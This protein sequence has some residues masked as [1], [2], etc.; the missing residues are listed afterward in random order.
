M[1]STKSKKGLMI[2]VFS[3]LIL[4]A[5]LTYFL[6]LHTIF[7]GLVPSYGGGERFT[8]SEAENYTFQI[9]W[10]AHTK[11]HLTLQ[12]NDIV[13]LYV[14]NEYV[15]DCTHY[16]FVVEPD[17]QILILLKSDAPVSGMFMAWQEVPFENQILALTLVIIGLLGIGVII[18]GKFR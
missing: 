4:F 3:L 18:A 8:L 7:P 15:C 13:E 9:P 1:F 6:Y 10:S 16:N 12:A 11:L 17:E 5:G 2:L 14:D